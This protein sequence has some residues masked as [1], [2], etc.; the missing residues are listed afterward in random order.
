MEPK[1]ILSPRLQAVAAFIPKGTILGDIG[2]D[3]AYLPIAVIQ[4]GL[5]EKAIACDL[6][7]GPLAIAEKNIQ[8]AG[9]YGKIETRLGNGLLPLT[10]GEADCIVI[11]GMG[12]MR[13]WGII[14]EGMEQA[15]QGKLILQPQH[16]I[17]LLRKNLHVAG[18]EILDETLVRENNHFYVVM[19]AEYNGGEYSWNER[20]YFLGKFLIEKTGENFSEFM[21][22]ER[23]KINKYISQ[24]KDAK[25]LACA[26]KR[27]DWLKL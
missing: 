21:C 17:P 20:E 24:V 10:P 4:Q 8:G 12:G 23:E 6:H 7:P 2:T 5:C 25:S 14:S 13:I 26:K 3:H 27:L 16:D 9:L 1:I 19:S 11:A 18:F 22:H 15:Q